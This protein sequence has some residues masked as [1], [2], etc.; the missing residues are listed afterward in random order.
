ML[1]PIEGRE[2]GWAFN[3]FLTSLA[4]LPPDASDQQDYTQMSWKP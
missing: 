2:E 3:Q 1:V 4:A